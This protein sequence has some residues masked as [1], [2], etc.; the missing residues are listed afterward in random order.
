MLVLTVCRHGGMGGISPPSHFRIPEKRGKVLG[1][2]D[3]S[4]RSNKEFLYT[5]EESRLPP[6]GVAF[7][8]TLRDCPDTPQEWNAL[9]RGLEW[10]LRRR[11]LV[12]GHLIT[13]WQ[14]RRVPHL[15]AALFWDREGIVSSKFRKELH[16]ALAAEDSRQLVELLCVLVRF[17]WLDVLRKRGHA[18]DHGA[19]FALPITDPMGWFEYVSKHA[20][21]GLS[22]YQRSP[23]KI[24]PGWLAQESTPRMWR[25]VGDWPVIDPQKV[26]IEDRGWRFWY[27]RR[28][29]HWRT[30]KA[31]LAIAEAA[32]RFA[33]EPGQANAWRWIHAK[34]GLVSARRSARCPDRKLCEVRG[35]NEWVP[36][37]V[38]LQLLEFMRGQGAP[39]LKG[40]RIEV[41]RWNR[42]TGEI[43][44]GSRMDWRK[45]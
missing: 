1:W 41:E 36:G 8:G 13:E 34:R 20:A 5:V 31:R 35:W 7:T 3:R 12:L 17:A 26:G 38:Q 33:R 18:A 29:R 45:S 6:L 37:S 23:E 21:R 10:R 22:H 44:M 15:H 28:M 42:E 43:Y 30:A 40:S 24:P 16:A 14:A 9:L 4:I 27:R 11:G 39:L 25:K 2:S 32:Q 19:Q